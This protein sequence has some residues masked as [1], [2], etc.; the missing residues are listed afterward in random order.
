MLNEVPKCLGTLIARHVTI[1]E[2]VDSWRDFVFFFLNF[3]L[4]EILRG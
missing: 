1:D 2:P 4:C 3:N